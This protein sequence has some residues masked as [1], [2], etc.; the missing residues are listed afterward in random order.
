[1][2]KNKYGGVND[3]PT[4]WTKT[5]E[6]KRVYAL[7]FDMLRRCYDNE[8]LSR[9]R[10]RTYSDCS[11]CAR[12]FYLSNFYADIQKLPGYL[13]WSLNGKMSIDKDLFSQGSKEY[14]PQNC[15]FVPAAVNTSEMGRRNIENIR[16]LHEAQKTRYVLSKGSERRV[17]PS[18]KEAC[19]AI[20][21]HQCS[22]AS[23]YRRGGKC[24]GYSISK[25]DGGGD[26]A[27]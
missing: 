13:E 18:E 24:K 19:A 1:M 10:G 2:A 6:N 12:W 4:G 17:F 7:W 8:Q 11:V 23:C 26:N 22:I 15:C 14:N 21:V 20:G 5:P 27:D 25:M 16:K 9:S 3:M